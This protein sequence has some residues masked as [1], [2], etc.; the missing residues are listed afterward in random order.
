MVKIVQEKLSEEPNQVHKQKQKK[1]D[2]RTNIKIK[3]L[4]YEGC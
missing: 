2:M 3:I 1:N 4:S